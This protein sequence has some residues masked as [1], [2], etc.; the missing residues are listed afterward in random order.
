VYIEIKSKKGI[1]LMIVYIQ[2]RK[3][4]ELRNS[5]KENIQYREK[6]GK[7]INKT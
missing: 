5:H 4:N 2:L 3:V 1:S 7:D 6:R